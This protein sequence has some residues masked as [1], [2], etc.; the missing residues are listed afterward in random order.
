MIKLFIG[1]QTTPYLV[2]ETLLT[3]IATYFANAMKWDDRSS[4]PSGILR[5]PDDDED[6]WKVL[7]HWIIK[8]KLPTTR[9]GQATQM[10]WVHCWI[11]GDKYNIAAFQDDVMVELVFELAHQKTSLEIVKTAFE[12]TIEDCK[13]RKLMAEETVDL[14]RTTKDWCHKKLELL[15]GVSGF[16]PALLKAM[17]EHDLLLDGAGDTTTLRARMTSGGISQWKAYTVGD[18]PWQHWIYYARA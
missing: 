8:G 16:T 7:L 5:F 15:D 3:D 10:L 6:A 18:G 1:Q 9:S 17:D 12:G 11:L 4:E 14:I 2:Q 13:L